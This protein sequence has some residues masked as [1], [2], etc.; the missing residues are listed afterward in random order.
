MRGQ[1]GLRPAQ[2]HS[3]MRTRMNERVGDDQV[4][5]PGRPPAAPC[6]PAKPLP[7]YS[8]ASLPKIGL[9]AFIKSSADGKNSDMLLDQACGIAEAKIAARALTLRGVRLS[10]Q[11]RFDEA[12][13][14]FEDAIQLREHD[15][16]SQ[17]ER[18]D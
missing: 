7:R 16:Q 12:W 1:H 18:Q 4:S 15:S 5:R 8:A 17:S 9:L 14:Y 3:I 13:R 2:L 10:D 6:W 11:C